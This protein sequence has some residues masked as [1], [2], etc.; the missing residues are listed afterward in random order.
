MRNI[1]ETTGDVNTV[2]EAARLHSQD[3]TATAET[4][5]QSIQRLEN[6]ELLGASL[7]PDYRIAQQQVSSLLFDA[8]MAHLRNE[9]SEVGDSLDGGIKE[10]L[11]FVSLRRTFLGTCRLCESWNR[12]PTPIAAA[13]AVRIFLKLYKLGTTLAFYQCYLVK[14]FPPLDLTSSTA[15][16]QHFVDSGCG[17]KAIKPGGRKAYFRAIRAFLN[18]V[19]SPASGLGFEPSDNPVTWVRSP[20][21]TERI[22]PAQDEKSLAVLLFHVD[23]TR[24]K[25]FLSTLIDSSGRLSEVCSINEADIA[26]DRQV[27]K[28]IGKGGREVLMPFSTATET[29]LRDWLAEYHPTGG[30]IWGI[31]KNGMVSM[32]RRLERSSGIKCNAHT[33]RRGFASI[34]RRNG[35]DSLDIMKLGHWR[36]IRM[37][38]K[39]TE[40][41]DFEDSQKHYKAPMERLA[42]ATGG[43][44]EMTGGL[45]KSSLVPRPRIGL[46]TRGLS[47]RCS[48][49]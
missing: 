8:L 22:M 5:L 46:G 6:S 20:K 35:V 30:S 19:Y 11:E 12:S 4:L 31:G 36:S 14:S 27:I 33:F 16:I 48:T 39:Y 49:S 29:L 15:E 43:L 26:W 23:T 41:V 40:S 17:K 44:Q 21:V 3:L 10:R 1:A 9:W 42:D 32:L 25:A 28:V 24:D 37:V 7:T 38:Q 34:L 18:W 47:V 2:E 13:E 45:H